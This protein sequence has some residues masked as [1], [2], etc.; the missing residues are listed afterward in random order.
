MTKILTLRV[1][2]PTLV[3]RPRMTDNTPTK[4]SNNVSKCPYIY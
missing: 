2:G 4:G 1:Q 3:I